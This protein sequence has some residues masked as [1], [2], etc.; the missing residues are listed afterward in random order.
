MRR[1][2]VRPAPARSKTELRREKIVRRVTAGP[3]QAETSGAEQAML[4]GE[5]PEIPAPTR[6]ASKSET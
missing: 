6:P 1:P 3:R 2:H 4:F 5:A